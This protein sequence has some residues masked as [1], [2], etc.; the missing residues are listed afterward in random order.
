MRKEGTPFKGS[1]DLR[2]DT[3]VSSLS[4]LIVCSIPDLELRT[5][6]TQTSQQ[7]QKKKKNTTKICSLVRGTEEETLAKQNTFRQ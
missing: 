6:A 5:L 2:K 4:F 3:M 1:R 7:M